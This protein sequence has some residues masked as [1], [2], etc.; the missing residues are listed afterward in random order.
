[1]SKAIVP[2]KPV[3]KYNPN[4][5]IP[6]GD[7]LSFDIN[8][9]KENV[10]SACSYRNTAAIEESFAKIKIGSITIKMHAAKIKYDDSDVFEW[11]IE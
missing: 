11:G 9:E 1:M 5:K 7:Y 10:R 3:V 2:V 8:N 6:I 4:I